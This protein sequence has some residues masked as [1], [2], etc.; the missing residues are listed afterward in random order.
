MYIGDILFHPGD[1]NL[2]SDLHPKLRE[3]LLAA[4]C[5]DVRPGNNIT[6]CRLRIAKLQLLQPKR[7]QCSP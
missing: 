5:D 3:E 6:T 7:R 1:S 4:E 2:F